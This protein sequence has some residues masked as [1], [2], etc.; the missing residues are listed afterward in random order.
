[1]RDYL[2]PEVVGRVPTGY[3]A[4]DLAFMF[5]VSVVCE[6]VSQLSLPFLNHNGILL[7]SFAHVDD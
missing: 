6:C 5:K 4:E 7:Y 3:P 1:M 2:T